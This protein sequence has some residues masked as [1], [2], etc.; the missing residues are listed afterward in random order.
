MPK[1]GPRGLRV[2]TYAPNG[3]PENPSDM[4]VEDWRIIDHFMQAAAAVIAARHRE[5][6]EQKEENEK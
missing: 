4:D 6:R 5:K 1:R 3:M 2:P